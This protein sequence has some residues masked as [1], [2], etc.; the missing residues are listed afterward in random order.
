[1]AEH[2]EITLIQPFGATPLRTQIGHSPRFV[3]R[4]VDMQVWVFSHVSVTESVQLWYSV[5]Y[6]CACVYSHVMVVS[7]RN[8]SCTRMYLCFCS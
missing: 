5:Q 7:A 2:V 8:F 4:Y 1:M 6:V 3:L